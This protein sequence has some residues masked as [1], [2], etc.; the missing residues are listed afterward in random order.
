M[1]FTCLLRNRMTNVL[2]NEYDAKKIKCIT[3]EDEI[4][5]VI[6]L[7]ISMSIIYIYLC[8]STQCPE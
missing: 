5:N 1:R 2:G 3:T 8:V 6:L 7:S 4:T